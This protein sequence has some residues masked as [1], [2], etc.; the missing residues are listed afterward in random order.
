MDLMS[1]PVLGDVPE[2]SS[3]S[4]RNVW[5]KPKEVAA[6]PIKNRTCVSRGERECQPKNI[7]V[8]QLSVYE[9]VSV[10]SVTD[11][12]IC[13]GIVVARCNGR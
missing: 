8:R 13:T 10:I 6:I 4:R 2:F 5:N 12:A 11:T 9:G 3:K 7:Y 1:L